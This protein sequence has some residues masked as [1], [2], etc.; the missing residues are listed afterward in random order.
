MAGAVANG[1]GVIDSIIVLIDLLCSGGIVGAGGDRRIK[2]NQDEKDGERYLS[3]SPCLSDLFELED[4]L[5]SQL[6]VARFVDGV[7]DLA[8][9]VRGRERRGSH[10]V[11]RCAVAWR[12]QAD[13]VEGI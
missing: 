1:E 2:C 11:D 6:D 7:G 4:E 10:V 9:C 12:C 5:Q 8:E 3:P 13:Q